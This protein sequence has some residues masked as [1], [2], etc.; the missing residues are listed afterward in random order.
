MPVPIR[1]L[2]LEDRPEDAELVVH[3]L[4]RSQFEPDW[5][6]VETESEYNAHL[7]WQPDLI[8]ADYNMP[9]LD[10]PRALALLKDLDMDIP[11]IV[12]SGAIGEDTAV[13]MMRQ[14][15]TDYLIKD[16]L[17]RLGPAVRHALAEK[18]L[19]EET[20]RAAEAL[21][22][23]EI[24]FYSF[25][26][27]SPALAF[28][29]D[30][31]GRILYMNNTCEQV[32][33][34]R[35][36]E[37]EGK[38]DHELWPAAVAARLR[39]NDLAVLESRETSRTVEEISVRNG[40]I[41]QMLSFRFPF[42]DAAGRCLL[43]GVSV[44]ISEQVRAEQALSE[45]LAVKEVLLRELHHRVKNNLQVICS[46]LTMQAAAVADPAA[47]EAFEETQKRVQ[48]MAL[49]HERLN[50]DNLDCLEFREYAEALC[51][52]LLYSC[53]KDPDSIRLRFELNPV[54]LALAQAIPCGLILNELVTNVLKHAFPDGRAGE[55]F[56]TLTCD[57]SGAVR[58]SVADN[59]VGLPAGFD[60]RKSPSLGLRIVDVLRRQLDATLDQT[61][62]GGQAGAA[63]TAFSLT[64]SKAGW[65]S[66]GRRPPESETGSGSRSLVSSAS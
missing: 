59:G 37:C 31:D 14:G 3:E 55:I 63:G 65:E 13:A 39:A 36:A 54:S 51:R 7:G 56:V 25:M 48:S 15:A 11:F 44:D 49:I 38:L 5:R 12:V 61:C 21:R 60:W 8:L 19:R 6:R 10:A 20:R 2:I 22:V 28:I 62:A 43:G 52:D 45:A 41:L 4:R 57:K 18:Q 42:T 35:L 9:L 26:N 58:L 29:K 66:H 16:R 27:N 30:E 17:A 23:S 34:A 53:A 33:G 47:K 32:W 46:L 1:V 50:R 64:F 24:R 40:R